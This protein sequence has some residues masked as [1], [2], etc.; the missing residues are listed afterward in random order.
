MFINSI[1]YVVYF[2]F[3]LICLSQFNHSFSV[4]DFGYGVSV[5]SVTLFVSVLC[6][7]TQIIHTECTSTLVMMVLFYTLFL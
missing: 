3:F 7:C 1:S 5:L 2:Y 4:D 6:K